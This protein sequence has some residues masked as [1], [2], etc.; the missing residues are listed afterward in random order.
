[1]SGA[2]EAIVLNKTPLFFPRVIYEHRFQFE[3]QCHAGVRL[4]PDLPEFGLTTL[5]NSHG[6]EP[7]IQIRL[8]I[9]IFIYT[10]MQDAL[11]T[12]FVL[13]VDCNFFIRS[14]VFSFP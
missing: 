10:S 1:M 8:N 11:T 13:P 7:N 2:E 3:Y 14:Q 12:P 6:S 5:L 9:Y 4:T